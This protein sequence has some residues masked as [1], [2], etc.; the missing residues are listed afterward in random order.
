MCVNIS[1]LSALLYRSAPFWANSLHKFIASYREYKLSTVQPTSHV[2]HQY[3][4]SGA[5]YWDSMQDNVSVSL[6]PSS[7]LLRVFWS[8][9]FSRWLPRCIQTTKLLQRCSLCS[10]TNK[11][12]C[13][14]LWFFCFYL[15]TWSPVPS[16]RETWARVLWISFQL[17]T[18]YQLRRR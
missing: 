10:H 2:K 18:R 15:S 3:V 16:A 12:E 13:D 9:C 11:W 8:S 7:D 5:I 1:F 4:I 6:H 14:D 17:W